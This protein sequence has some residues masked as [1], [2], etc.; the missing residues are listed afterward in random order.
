MQTFYGCGYNQSQKEVNRMTNTQSVFSSA[1][2]A[3]SRQLQGPHFDSWYQKQNQN[4]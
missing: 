3:P 2:Q 4:E 1:T